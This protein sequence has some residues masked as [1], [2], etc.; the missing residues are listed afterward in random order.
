ML[1]SGLRPGCDGVTNAVR[2]ILINGNTTETMT[3]RLLAAAQPLLPPG[4]RIEGR[5]AAFGEPY[6]ST[7]EASAIAG[8]AVAVVAREIAAEP[9]QPDAVH[10]ACFGDPGLLAAREILACPVIGMAEASCHAACQLGQ[11]FSIITGGPAWG[12]M[13]R[14]FV[15]SIGLRH[16]LASVRTLDLSGAEIAARPQEAR[17]LIEAEARAAIAEDRADVVILGGAGL[18]GFADDL[19][20]SVNRPV[21]DSLAL[22]VRQAVALAGCGIGCKR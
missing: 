11:R 1:G 12:P 22:S 14:E 6:I 16:R 21:L 4:A 10:I 19:R 2:L 18:I 13:L 8:H 5:T 15:A 20:C 9:E 3:Q 17:G 7:R